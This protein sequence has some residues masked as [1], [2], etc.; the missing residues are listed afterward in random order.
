MNIWSI[1]GTNS[2]GEEVKQYAYAYPDNFVLEWIHKL[3]QMVTGG[4][5]L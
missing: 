2:N 3:D 4:L 1:C 5:L